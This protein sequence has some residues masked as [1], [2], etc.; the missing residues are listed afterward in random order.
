MSN[1]KHHFD[2]VDHNF[3]ALRHLTSPNPST[4]VDW[5]T[6][7]IFYMALHHIHAYLADKKNMH[8]SS[9]TNLDSI[10]SR[11]MKLKPIY[12]KYRHLKD[13]SEDARYEG[14]ILSIY[15]LR[16]TVLKF[17]SEIEKSIFQLLNLK[18]RPQYDLYLLFPLN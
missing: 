7:V 15:Q 6:T 16:Q 4:Y 17:Y 18:N 2:V 9:H 1:K 13:D 3:E 14:K 5:C 10:I 12:N 8:P 11:D